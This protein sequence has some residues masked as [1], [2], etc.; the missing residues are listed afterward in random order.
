[1]AVSDPLATEP[2]M[3]AS[4]GVGRST[5]REALRILELLGVV[6][7][8]PG[9][10]GGPMV[11][12]PDSRHLASTMALLMQCSDTAFRSVVELRKSR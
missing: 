6:A 7:I 10:G 11:A 12:A 4:H 1:M 9:R 5:L 2:R 8:R 3:C